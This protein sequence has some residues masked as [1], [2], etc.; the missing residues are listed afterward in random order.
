MSGALL[1]YMC[2]HSAKFQRSVLNLSKDLITQIIPMFLIG[3]N[4]SISGLG[5][6]FS[7]LKGSYSRFFPPVLKGSYS[8]KLIDQTR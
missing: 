7:V 5:W 2:E 6:I 4:Q 3:L 8:L 1:N